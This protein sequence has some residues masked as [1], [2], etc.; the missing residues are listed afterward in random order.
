[1]TVTGMM[2][3]VPVA[4]AIERSEDYVFSSASSTQ[5]DD[6]VHVGIKVRSNVL[7]PRSPS[8]EILKIGGGRERYAI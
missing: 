3:T 8:Y 2:I 4:F 1:M 5:E 6:V 7:L